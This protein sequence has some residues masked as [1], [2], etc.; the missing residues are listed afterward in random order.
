MILAV[1]LA[2]LNIVF[3]KEGARFHHIEHLYLIGATDSK[4]L[5]VNGEE[6]AVHPMGG[7]V[8]YVDCHDGTN[9]V[10]VGGM[11]RTFTVAEKKPNLG[12]V[13][14]PLYNKLEYASDTPCTNCQRVVVLDPGHGGKK[15]LGTLSPHNLPEKDLNLLLALAVRR[16]LVDK[17]IEV[18]MTREDDS[19]V[20]LYER[21]RVAHERKAAAFVSIHHNAPPI[22][23]DPRKLRYHAV[24]VWNDLG[25]R[26][27][28]RINRRM[29]ETLE[30][31]N[32][33][34]IR[35]NYAVTR[36][37][38]IP[39]CLIEVDFA[40]TPEGEI[41]CWNGERR[42]RNAKAIARGIV[43]WLESG[44]ISGK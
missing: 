34:V 28:E 21:A 11:R 22:D 24:Y 6:V 17:G 3:P 7:W 26:L 9:V 23:R 4:T 27:A 2:F 25:A 12:E 35:A 10:E 5:S 8:A 30:I 33:G 18:I 16:E 43:D 14:V 37:P 42:K 44:I 32:N 29:A 41:D 36:S 31:P 13:E 39:S 1:L 20:A 38:E 40:T 19:G 15:D